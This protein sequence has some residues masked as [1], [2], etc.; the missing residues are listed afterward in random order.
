MVSGKSAMESEEGGAHVQGFCGHAIK[1]MGGSG[2]GIN[3]EG[4][5]MDAWKKRVRVILLEGLVALGFAFLLR[6]MCTT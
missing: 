2:K 3:P 1:E 4:G 5:G 6:G